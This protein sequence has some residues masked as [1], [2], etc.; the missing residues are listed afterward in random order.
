VG[1]GLVTAVLCAAAL[2]ISLPAS[3]IVGG[4]PDGAAHPYVALITDG[5]GYCSGT[6]ISP[7]VLVTAAH[8]FTSSSWG[9]DSISGAPQVLASF[10]SDLI[11][12]PREERVWWTG[13]YYPDPSF[14][15]TKSGLTG[16]STHDTAIVVF[17]AA[18]CHVP[19]D[20][21]GIVSCGPIPAS[22]TTDRYG[23]LPTVGLT[24]SLENGSSVDVVGYGAQDFA[25]GGG[26]CSAGCQPGVDADKTRYVGTTSLIAGNDRLGGEYIKLHENVSGVC[27]GDSGGP[28]LL[29]GTDVVLAENSFVLSNTCGGVSYGQRLDQRSTQD[30][31]K[32]TA[33]ANGGSLSR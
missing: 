11:N 15:S 5:P 1:K 4:Q 20:A 30:W 18:G 16:F 14:G 3:A 27:F 32:S 10:D 9:T 21:H 17:G 2:S 23:E 22:L 19:A 6:L 24:D 29:G 12:I 33:V 7:T 26:P 13:S 28:E 8:C 31:I 25:R